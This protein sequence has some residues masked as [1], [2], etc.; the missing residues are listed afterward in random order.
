MNTDLKNYLDQ[1]LSSELHSDR[2]K[3]LEPLI[4][5]LRKRSKA[6]LNFICTHNSRRS[7]MAQVW[8]QLAADFYH[9]DLKAYSGGVEVTACNER[10]KAAL[11]RAGLKQLSADGEINPIY[12]LSYS[13]D[14]AAIELSSKLFDDALNPNADFA[15]VMTCS[16][17]EENCPFVAGADQR[18]ALT[19]EDPKAFDDSPEEA[20]AY[21]RRCAQIAREMF[22]V[23]KTVQNGN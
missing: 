23:F 17:A 1:L 7:Q 19:Y 6:Q 12:K 3:A 22:Y 13:D 15:A 5:Y 20:Q 14:A 11:E 16:H 18:I 10:T 8:A 2:I 4:N 9:Y 21:D